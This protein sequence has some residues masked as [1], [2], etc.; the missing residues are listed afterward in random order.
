M[1]IAPSG[2]LSL[3][4]GHLRALVAASSSFQTWTGTASA[5]LAAARV[6]LCDLPKP[7]SNEEY[8]KA[9]LA[10][11]YP[12]AI[13]DFFH[14]Q[15]GFGGEAFVWDKEV[16]LGWVDSGVLSL[17]FV[18]L[19]DEDDAVSPADTLLA[20]T[21]DVGAVIEAMVALSGTSTDSTSYLTIHR[22]ELFQGPYRTDQSQHANI[23]DQNRI[24]F[25]VHWGI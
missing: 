11:Y 14:S 13:V 8:T 15:R 24:Q 6:H 18:E 7:S 22:L 4:L 21:N 19:V 3:P 10:A 16:E 23:G 1:P 2:I 12:C 9:E 17:D 25:K 5:A 20:F